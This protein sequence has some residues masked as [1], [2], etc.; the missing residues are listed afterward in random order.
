MSSRP[1]QLEERGSRCAQAL[2]SP[3]HHLCRIRDHELRSQRQ[4][5]ASGPLNS[6][7]GP[8]RFSRTIANVNGRSSM[9]SVR[10]TAITTSCSVVPTARRTNPTLSLR[11]WLYVP[12]AAMYHASDSTTSAIPTPPSCSWPEFLRRLCPS[13]SV[14]RAFL[15][16]WTSTATSP[17]A[18]RQRPPR[19]S[20]TTYSGPTD[21]SHDSSSAPAQL[22]L[23]A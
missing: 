5:A 23:K 20:L 6:M 19:P 14:M 13:D 17:Q 18:C 4:L 12:L 1:L 2:G 22:R 3:Q 15:S 8:W 11:H 21:Q 10:A 7:V 9:T 16:R